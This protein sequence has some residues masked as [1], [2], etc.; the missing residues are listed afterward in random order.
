MNEVTHRKGARRMADIPP[1]ILAQLNAG[2]LATANLPEGLA[3][4]MQVLML[5]TIPDLSRDLQALLADSMGLGVTRRMEVCG[6]IVL[7]HFGLDG[8]EAVAEHPSDTVRGW[9]CYAIGQAP[10][11]KLAARLQRLEPLANDPHFGVR[12]W[13]WIPMRSHIA[14]NVNQSV[15]VL[16][17]WANSEHVNLRRYAVEV[18]RPRGVW[19]SHIEQ[20]KLNP[21]IARPLLEANR[22]DESVYVQDSVANWLND[23]GKSQPA[24]V[25]G[26]VAEWLR[27]NTSPATERICRRALRNL[28]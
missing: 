16:T 27:G 17:P 22:A 3:I 23:A 15:K 18:T 24:W 14:S 26:I 20:F 19:T 9:A 4:D 2:T 28:P 13:A 8:L 1:E 7:A 6:A 5:A 25:H 12:E 21:D 10:K 11:L